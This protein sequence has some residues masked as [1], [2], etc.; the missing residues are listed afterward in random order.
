MELWRL[1]TER[2]VEFG[3][4]RDAGL[5]F[6]LKNQVGMDEKEAEDRL[7][8]SVAKFLSADVPTVPTLVRC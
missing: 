1:F 7:I 3:R 6:E 8:R 4:D 5:A 2:T